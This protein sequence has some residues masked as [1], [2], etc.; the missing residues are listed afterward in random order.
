MVDATHEVALVE[1]ER[2]GQLLL[3]QRAEV[4]K[5]G[6]DRVVSQQKV[7]LGQYRFQLPVPVLGRL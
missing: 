7:M 5:G 1:V 6:Q 4:V 3:G 2:I